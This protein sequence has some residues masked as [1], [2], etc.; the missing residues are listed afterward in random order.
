MKMA[1]S[2]NNADAA[3]R[4]GAEFIQTEAD[5][6]VTFAEVALSTQDQQR[7]SRNTENALKAYRS[8][9]HFAGRILL[10]DEQE[11]V[12]QAKMQKLRE[13]LAKL[14]ERVE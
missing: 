2:T 4:A 10:S 11:T 5:A 7:R 6:G 13:Q 3:A 8:V 14:G 12:V 1:N 9:L